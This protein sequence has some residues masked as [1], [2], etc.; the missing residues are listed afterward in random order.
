MK[1]ILPAL[2]LLILIN[3]CGDDGYE[4]EYNILGAWA[5]TDFN[6]Y[7][8]T[9]G[10][11]VR[12]YI[13]GDQTFILLRLNFLSD[14]DSLTYDGFS[15]EVPLDSYNDSIFKNF[16]KEGREFEIINPVFISTWTPVSPIRCLINEVHPSGFTLHIDFDRDNFFYGI[17][18]YYGYFTRWVE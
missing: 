18:D 6:K 2:M 13:P 1:L 16:P 8:F 4:E 9:D 12:I 10:S 14:S 5:S 3:G 17:N 11:A 15:G 7:D